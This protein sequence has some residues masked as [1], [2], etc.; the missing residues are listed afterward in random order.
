MMKIKK[1]VKCLDVRLDRNVAVFVLKKKNA[2]SRK[3]ATV[4]LINVRHAAKRK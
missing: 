1:Q 2:P 4:K 3:N